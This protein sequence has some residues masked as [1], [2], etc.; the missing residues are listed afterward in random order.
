MRE[1]IFVTGNNGKVQSMRRHINELGADIG[2]IQK[3]MDIIEPQAD[4]STEVAQFKA[5]Q[6]YDILHKPVLVDDS[7]FHIT[8]LGGFPGPY[9]KY[10]LTSI[11]IDGILS[12]MKGKTDRSA[13]FTSSLVYI[14]ELGKEHIFEDSPLRGVITETID[15]YESEKSWSELFKIFIP[16]GFDKVLARMTDEERN[17]MQT[18]DDKSYRDFCLWIDKLDK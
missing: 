5:K 17:K 7:S 1:V 10:M 8:A 16:N 6:A 18:N 3:K 9:I 12:F 13:Y 2:I 4:N 14:D 11:G 15:N